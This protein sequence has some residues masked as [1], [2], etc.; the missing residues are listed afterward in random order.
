MSREK[1]G[2]KEHATR[3]RE[4]ADTCGDPKA[5]AGFARLQ[6]GAGDIEG[7]ARTAL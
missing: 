3:L 2:D 1:A 6:Y 5:L 7:A 4:T